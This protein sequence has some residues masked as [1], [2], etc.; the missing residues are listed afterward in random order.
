[1]VVVD[2]GR[3]RGCCTKQAEAKAEAESREGDVPLLHGGRGV[4]RALPVDS[5]DES[6][7]ESESSSD[8]DQPS[9]N[10]SNDDWARPGRLLQLA[11]T[12]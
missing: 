9:E 2:R 8:E 12:I 5:E 10:E 7:D 6:E 1:V 3:G 11:T 4:K